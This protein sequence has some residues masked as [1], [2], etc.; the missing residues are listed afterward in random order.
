MIEKKFIQQ[1]IREQIIKEWFENNLEKTEFSRVE[2]VKTPVGVKVVIY[3]SKPGL[4]VGRGGENIRNITETLTKKFKLDSP[5]VEVREITEPYLDAQ[6]VAEKIANQLTHFGVGRF[7]SIGHRSIAEVMKAGA[8]GV[9]IKIS[10]K[11]PGKRARYWRFYKGF[12]PKCGEPSD[13]LVEIGF[14]EAKLKIGVVGVTVKILPPALKMPDDITYTLEEVSEIKKK[15]EEA[16]TEETTT[17][18]AKVE[19]AKTE[20]AKTEETKVEETKKEEVKKKKEKNEKE[21]QKEHAQPK[22]EQNK[23][24]QG[25]E[26]EPNK[27]E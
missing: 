4:I 26:K 25:K 21:S 5:Q 2:I 11:V 14:K 22:K 15:V 3:T 13:E 23:E 8:Q 16:K 24:K 10:G 9:E 18:E 19:E 12:L 20:E 7:K 27:A 1:R 17:E 6:I